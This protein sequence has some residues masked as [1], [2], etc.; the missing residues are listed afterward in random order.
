[1]TNVS[2]LSP[3]PPMPVWLRILGVS[4]CFLPPVVYAVGLFIGSKS[5]EEAIGGILY[6]LIIG[7]FVFI[8][9]LIPC[10]L[11][12]LCWL[13][14]W[15]PGALAGSAFLGL[16]GLG[17]STGQTDSDIQLGL[18]LDLHFLLIGVLLWEWRAAIKRRLLLARP[19]TPETPSD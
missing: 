16:V 1:M 11:P 8:L 7:A 17:F 2:A 14:G 6:T 13:L 4:V 12:P 3:T 18:P 5:V 10:L 9:L 19:L 15:R